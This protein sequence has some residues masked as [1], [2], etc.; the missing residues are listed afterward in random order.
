MDSTCGAPLIHEPALLA[1]PY[2]SDFERSHRAGT[3][4]LDCR[5]AARARIRDPVV[6]RRPLGRRTLAQSDGRPRLL[7]VSRVPDRERRSSLSRR[8][9]RL[10]PPLSLPSGGPWLSLSILV[11]VDDPLQLDRRG[12]R[13]CSADPIRTA[14]SDDPGTDSV[15]RIDSGVFALGSG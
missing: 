4:T 9:S 11:P 5:L 1:S 6:D 15:G 14:L 2:Q 10:Q 13:G 3:A 8:L 7:V 12:L